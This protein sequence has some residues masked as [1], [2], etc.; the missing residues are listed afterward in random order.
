MK[1]PTSLLY[2][3]HDKKKIAGTVSKT[4]NDADFTNDI[5]D[6]GDE[7]PDIDGLVTF[8]MPRKMSEQKEPV[9]TQK[10]TFFHFFF[11]CEELQSIFHN[12]DIYF[13]LG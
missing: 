10:E 6:V 7:D 11:A 2:D 9:T 3:E 4:L 8:I 5:L 13:K 1:A 12:V